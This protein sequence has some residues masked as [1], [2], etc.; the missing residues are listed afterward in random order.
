[1]TRARLA[2]WLTRLVLWGV[3]AAWFVWVL[4]HRLWR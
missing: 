3:T 1:M 4:L 2:T